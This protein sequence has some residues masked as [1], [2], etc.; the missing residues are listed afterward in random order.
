MS[1]INR[2]RNGGFEQS[3]PPSVAPFWTGSAGAV[4]E[5]GGSQLLEDNNALLPVGDSIEQP[6][7]PLQLLQIYKFEAAFDTSALT[8]TIDIEISG[9]SVRKFQGLNVTGLYTFY[10][11][12]FTAT[13]A[14]VTL[15]IT[16]NTDS[17]V[18]IDAVSVK[19]A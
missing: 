1:N 13:A 11:F 5:T 12:T 2:V 18:R 3:T 7:L 17:D 4:T 9:H 16:N 19:L 6:L 10:N 14:N 15:K 8:G